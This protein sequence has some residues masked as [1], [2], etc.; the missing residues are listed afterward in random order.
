[1]TLFPETM[2]LPTHSTVANESAVFRNCGFDGKFE[3]KQLL[4]MNIYLNSLL[5]TSRTKQ[6]HVLQWTK[7]TTLLS[8]C[9]RLLV[10]MTTLSA[11][12]Q[13]W[14]WWDLNVCIVSE[15]AMIANSVS[16]CSHA[17]WFEVHCKQYFLCKMI[18]FQKRCKHAMTMTWLLLI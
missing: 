6:S 4:N 13:S 18:R 8:L 15:Q 14:G 16:L 9:D 12:Q 17:K 5:T 1:M 11:T 3:W 2:Y 7:L 10:E